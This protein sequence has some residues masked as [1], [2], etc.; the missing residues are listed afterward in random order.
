MRYKIVAI[1]VLIITTSLTAFCDI[2][3]INNKMIKGNPPKGLVISN[4]KPPKPES[5]KR[6]TDIL[7]SHGMEYEIVDHYEFYVDAMQPVDFVILSGGGTSIEL[8]P[9]LDEERELI[10]Q[11][12]VPIFGICAGFQ[13]IVNAYGGTTVELDELCNEIQTIEL[14]DIGK[15]IFEDHET[16]DV[17]QNHGWA[18]RELPEGFANLGF[19]ENGYEI[20]MHPEKSIMGVQFHPEVN[21]NNNGYIVLDYFLANVVQYNI[22]R[23]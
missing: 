11:A 5:I 3:T 14:T 6:I 20:F 13:I 15:D 21:N 18:V 4:Y 2:E 17:Y 9:E 10:R 12:P 7:D 8:N 19:S 16:L 23:K 1:I 22:S